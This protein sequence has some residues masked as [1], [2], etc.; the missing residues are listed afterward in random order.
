MVSMSTVTEVLL[1]DAADALKSRILRFSEL[2]ASDRAFLAW[3]LRECMAC[4]DLGALATSAATNFAKTRSYHDL[5]TIGYAAHWVGLDETQEETFR[6]GLRWLCG[7]SPVIDGEPA[8]FFTDAA[9]LLGL[10]LGASVLAGEVG[11]TTSQWMLSFVPRAAELHAVE[12]WQRCL[13][14]AALHALGS[15]EIPV[16]SE[17]EVADIRTAL[18]ARSVGSIE[19]SA[20]ETEEDER[21]TLDLLKQQTVDELPTVRAALRL[22]AFSW[23]CRSAPV[24]VP[25]RI[26]ISDVCRLLGRVPSG[27]RR[28]AWDEKSRT[29]GGEARK[30]NV[31]HE[32]H[33]QDLLYFL[34]APILPDLKDEEY[35]AS[36][37]QK[38][39][40]TDLFV[41]SL[42]LI[43][44][45][46]FLRANDRITR[47]IDEIGSD[48]S[49]YLK[50]G[51][52]YSGIVAF[53]WDDSRRTE[54][55]TLLRNGL[56]EI[57][58]ILDAIIV[59]RPGRM[60]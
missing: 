42:K 5:A 39:P 57:R 16:P 51:T 3:T 44:E 2:S 41:P 13:F 60:S 54:E 35:F 47:V 10:A 11:A 43:V 4:D 22:A 52:D 45:V 27:L 31:D 48:A 53:I 7:R 46:K 19:A 32:Y 37:G 55:H 25:G 50:E 33:V 26:S 9:A 28:W 38:Q 6:L 12:T 15:T 30:W 40:R 24:V 21:L 20:K 56:C 34:L 8:P 29:K 59:P 14:S 23:I 49:L 58:G 1:K 18:R 36:L 17:A